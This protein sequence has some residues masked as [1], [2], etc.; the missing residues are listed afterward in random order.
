MGDLAFIGDL[1]IPINTQYKPDEAFSPA[2]GYSPSEMTLNTSSDVGARDPLRDLGDVTG[3]NI[4]YL[5]N[6]YIRT[7][8]F[9]KDNFII[10]F[11]T[12]PEKITDSKNANYDDTFFI[13]GS[14]PLKT[15][16]NSTARTIAFTLEFF[17]VIEV[18]NSIF[19]ATDGK[20]LKNLVDNARSLL[21]PN[22]KTAQIKPPT[23]C[24]VRLGGQAAMIG[25]CKSVNILYDGVK[26]WALH[27]D[28]GT[29]STPHWVSISFVFDEVISIP[30]SYQDIQTDSIAANFL[31]EDPFGNQRQ[32]AMESPF[33]Q[34]QVI[35]DTSFY[36]QT[37][38]V[39][40]VIGPPAPGPKFIDIV[41][42]AF[43]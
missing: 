13:A 28:Q 40:Q 38:T 25:V 36:T 39:S 27:S 29:P 26:P 32:A 35:S 8:D 17:D 31:S 30:L 5:N 21:Y 18:Q 41:A 3:T 7:M 9:E 19:S 23:K 11:Q 37:T 22:Y 14:S 12:M 24:L 10:P 4:P 1:Y 2:L 43:R 6:F 16:Q 15:Y 20:T 34:K 33:T 42:N